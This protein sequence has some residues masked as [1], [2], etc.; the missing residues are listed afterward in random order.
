VLEPAP[1]GLEL[2][3]R[4]EARPDPAGDRPQLALSDQG[5]DV[6]LGARELVGEF[7]D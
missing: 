6:V 4:N 1:V 7:S 5:A 2:V 3:A